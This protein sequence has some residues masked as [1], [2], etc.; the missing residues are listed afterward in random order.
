MVLYSLR[1]EWRL[2]T[3]IKIKYLILIKVAKAESP[4]DGGRAPRTRRTNKDGTTAPEFASG[5]CP[6][7]GIGFGL[8][9]LS[10]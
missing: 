4:K 9:L 5:G 3:D 10:T 2:L 7:K 6:V 8:D 1:E